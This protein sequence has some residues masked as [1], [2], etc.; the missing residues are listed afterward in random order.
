MKDRSPKIFKL[1]LPNGFLVLNVYVMQ[2]FA[3]KIKPFI[4]QVWNFPCT[5]SILSLFT[6]QTQRILSNLVQLRSGSQR[7]SPL[8]PNNFMIQSCSERQILLSQNFR[9]LDN[10]E[11]L[12]RFKNLER[13]ILNCCAAHRYKSR[14]RSRSRSVSPGRAPKMEY[15][16]SFSDIPESKSS[17]SQKHRHSHATERSDRWLHFSVL[18]SWLYSWLENPPLLCIHHM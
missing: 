11:Y 6:S 10:S 15:I 4:S 1:L 12:Q 16:T 5:I 8:S 18:Y 7:N 13:R 2:G 9:L 3:A 14:S 17:R